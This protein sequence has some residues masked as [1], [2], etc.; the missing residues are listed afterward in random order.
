M[1]VQGVCNQTSLDHWF[2][3]VAGREGPFPPPPFPHKR[4][5]LPGAQTPSS[6]PG[7]LECEV[8]SRASRGALATDRCSPSLGR[9]GAPAPPSLE[10]SEG[11]DPSLGEQTLALEAFRRRGG[12]TYGSRAVSGRP[13]PPAPAPGRAAPSRKGQGLC[14]SGTGSAVPAHRMPSTRSRGSMPTTGRSLAWEEEADSWGR[15]AAETGSWAWGALPLDSGTPPEPPMNG[16]VGDRFPG[17]CTPAPLVHP[18]AH[19]STPPSLTPAF[20]MPPKWVS[21][22]T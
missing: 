5:S 4:G 17:N 10:P 11:E 16:A 14:R 8:P 22:S 21:C 12:Q 7:S 19:R 20:R 3:E 2:M 9:G 6:P 18:W 13:C 15:P 1:S